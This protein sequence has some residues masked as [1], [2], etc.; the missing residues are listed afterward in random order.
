LDVY[1]KDDQLVVEAEPPGIKKEDVQVELEGGV[2]VIRGESRQE[3]EVRDED[4]Y[5][6][7]RSFGS[8]HRRVPLGFDVDP[9]HVQAS[10]ANGVLEVRIPKPA[11]TRTEG[12]RIQVTLPGSRAGSRPRWRP[13]GRRWLSSWP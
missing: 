9:S 4:Y 10:M 12:R 3:R 2:L 8:F 11:E 7:E 6:T 5:R 13:T 1:Q